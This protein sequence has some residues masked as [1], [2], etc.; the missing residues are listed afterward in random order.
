MCCIGNCKCVADH[1]GYINHIFPLIYWPTMTHV[2]VN[3]HGDED[4]D[5]CTCD[6]SF[7]IYIQLEWIFHSVQGLIASLR[8]RPE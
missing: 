3:H 4:R 2:C 8:M 5:Y 7:Q 6:L 1:Q